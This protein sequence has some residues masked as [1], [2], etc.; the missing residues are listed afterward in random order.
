LDIND[1]ALE[2]DK[3]IHITACPKVTT[4][5]NISP[6]QFYRYRMA[7]REEGRGSFHWLWFARR[8]AEYFTIAVLNR[9]ERNE[10]EHVKKQQ[11]RINLRQ[12]IARDYLAAIEQGLTRSGANRKLGWVFM[13]PK[14]WAGSRQY[15]QTKYADFMTIVRRVGNPTWLFL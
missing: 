9:I 8:L 12:I 6:R 10:M 13:T 3:Q 2:E 14:T 4:R 5:D 1:S 15:Y 7:M 11:R